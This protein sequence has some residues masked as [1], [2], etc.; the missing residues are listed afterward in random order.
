MFHNQNIP[1]FGLGLTLA[2][3]V[4]EGVA[5]GYLSLPS[6]ADDPLAVA[7]QCDGRHSHTVGIIDHQHQTPSL[8]GEQTDLPIIPCCNRPKA[9]YLYAQP[10][11]G[12]VVSV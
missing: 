7:G 4:Q 2:D 3:S 1:P 8:R 6:S 9:D 10:M 11:E 5:K 12:Q